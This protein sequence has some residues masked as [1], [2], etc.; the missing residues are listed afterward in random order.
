[1]DGRS[2]LVE[3]EDDAHVTTLT[4]ARPKQRNALSAPLLR[5]LLDHLRRI[6]AEPRVR[7]VVLAGQG[8]A[9]SAGH[10]LREI[11]ANADPQFRAE[12]FQLCSAVMLAIVGLRQPVI[13]KVH[14]IATA[15]GCQL[16]AS[17]DLAVAAESAR[18]ATPGVDIGLFCSTPMV[19]LTRNVGAKHAM[20]MLLTGNP[21]DAAEAE[22]LGL[23]NRVVPDDALDVAVAD[24]AEEIA[25]K[26]P[27]V[28]AIGKEAFR[29]QRDLPLTDAYAYTS[30]VMAANLAE[31][32][33]AEGISA[34]LE[35]RP[36]IWEAE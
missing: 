34:F 32:D 16:V 21:I 24:L 28:V 19:A 7:V 30:G 29:R 36:P 10:D 18:F 23:V 20:E 1:M 26:S 5:E 22:R 2:P 15:A 9:F 31:P 3:R 27:L 33:A 14:G 25:T 12:L 4:L 6:D 13:A 11:Q 8:P 17:C 35:K